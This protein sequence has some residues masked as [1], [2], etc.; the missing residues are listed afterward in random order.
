M[1]KT[2]GEEQAVIKPGDI[3]TL[4]N[5]DEIIVDAIIGKR[6]EGVVLDCRWVADG[7]YVQIVIEAPEEE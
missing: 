4:P 5:D 6:D 1:T 7:D 2:I 3:I